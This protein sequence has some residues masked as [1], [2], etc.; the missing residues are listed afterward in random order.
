MNLLPFDE[1]G[2]HMRFDAFC[3]KVLKCRNYKFLR[4]EYRR[5]GRYCVFSDLNADK[6]EQF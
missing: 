4:E 2:L 5:R 3:K 1:K 6:L